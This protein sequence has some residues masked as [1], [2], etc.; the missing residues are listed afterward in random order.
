MFALA[1]LLHDDLRGDGVGK[2]NNRR[3][4]IAKS[5]P[6][7]SMPSRII[8]LCGRCA[9]EYRTA[10]IIRRTNNDIKSD[11][12]ICRIRTGYDYN[13]TAEIKGQHN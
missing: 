13:V 1:V 2:K 11:C 5:A 12:D 10:Y 7:K 8:T 9:D 4:G 6:Y 3:L